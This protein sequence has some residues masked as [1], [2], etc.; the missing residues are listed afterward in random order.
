MGKIEANSNLFP[1]RDRTEK[2]KAQETFRI[3]ISNFAEIFHFVSSASRLSLWTSSVRYLHSATKEHFFG[4]ILVFWCSHQR[5]LHFFR[6][7]FKN[8]SN[9]V[10]GS[11]QRSYHIS[12]PLSG[13]WLWYMHYALCTMYCALCIQI[14]VMYIQEL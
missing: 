9:W 7:I 3:S 6:I 11:F 10:M 4:L 5:I 14:E 13:I 1:H 12:Y 8:Y 2:A